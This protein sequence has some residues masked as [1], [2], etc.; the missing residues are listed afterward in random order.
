MAVDIVRFLLGALI[1]FGV[2]SCSGEDVG[3][4]TPGERQLL[5][6][7]QI[8]AEEAKANAGDADAATRLANHYQWAMGDGDR[9]DLWLE[10]AV[11][12]GDHYAMLNLSSKLSARQ[13]EP[14]CKRAERLLILVLETKPDKKVEQDARHDL[15]LLR[16][17]VSGD[18]FC[19]EWLH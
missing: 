10:K 9:A 15:R 4:A 8:K 13:N 6:D 19:T 16:E 7:D 11:E 3:S 14:D 1:V 18:G 2:A 12:L 5:S 17:G